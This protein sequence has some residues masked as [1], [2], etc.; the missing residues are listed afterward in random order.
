M[1]VIAVCGPA[2]DG[3]A[4]AP[5]TIAWRAPETCPT[6][7]DVRQLLSQQPHDVTAAVSA[8]AEV[9]ATGS[10]YQLVLEVHANNQA[11][12]TR[13][14]DAQSC[15]ALA[16]AVALLVAVA[17]EGPPVEPPGAVPVPPEHLPQALAS[18]RAAVQPPPN[19]IAVEAVPV[20]SSAAA[21]PRIAGLVRVD[22]IAQTP[23]VLP[24]LV[25][26]GVGLAAGIRG[27]RWRVEARGSYFVLR[28][29]AR[30]LP[31]PDA[32]CGRY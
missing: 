12:Q 3:Q 21:A 31:R 20:P 5:A 4:P 17:A 28:T 27:S 24:S 14:V 7:D 10:G 29:S 16:Q 30:S 23:R 11:S 9:R 25:S 6:Q 1:T 22:A 19:A 8:H 32:W 2:A 18:P 26:A 13:V 15:E